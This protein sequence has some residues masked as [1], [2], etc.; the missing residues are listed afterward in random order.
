MEVQTKER[1]PL[2]TASAKNGVHR[3]QLRTRSPQSTITSL[4]LQVIASLSLI[5]L[6]RWYAYRKSQY[7]IVVIDALQ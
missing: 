3:H 4:D 7:L 5:D 2:L 6:D 1:A